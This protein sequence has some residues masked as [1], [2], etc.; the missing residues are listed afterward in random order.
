MK[1]TLAIVLLAAL[2]F[3]GTVGV[4]MAQDVTAAITGQVTDPS[5]GVLAGARVTAKDLDRGSVWNTDT[6]SG[7][8]YNLPR[9]PTG[10]YEIRVDHAGFRDLK[11]ETQA[12]AGSSIV[13]NLPLAVSSLT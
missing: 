8:Y 3:V 12:Q 5:G 9:V 7:G 11:Q 10:R 6:N 4:G 2:C 1:S 13:L